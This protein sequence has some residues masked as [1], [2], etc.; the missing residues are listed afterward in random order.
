[1]TA[2]TTPRSAST[3]ELPAPQSLHEVPGWFYRADILLF[4]WFLRRQQTTGL[5]GDLL[6]LGS[7]MGKSAVLMRAYL[8]EGENFTVCDLF[9]A[10]APD[11]HN[12]QETS[13]SYRTLTRQA[14]EAN[15][16]SFHDEL[17][18]VLHAPTSV[19]AEEVPAGSCRFVHVDAS[20]LY[21]HVRSDIANAR[22][23]LG[24][25]G[26]L[27]MDDYRSSHTPGVACATWQAVLEDGLR[28]VCLTNNKFYGTW[29][30]PGPL[31]QELHDALEA[32]GDCGLQWQYV[33]GQRLLLVSGKH[34]ELP[35]LPVSRHA[36]TAEEIAREEAAKQAE[37]ERKEAEKAAEKAARERA[38]AEKR[39]A[40]ERRARTPRARVV[41]AA[42]D[43]LPPVLTRAVVRAR[44]RRRAR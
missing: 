7:Y 5:R 9:G 28:P 3:D 29:E 33:S 41:R 36:R 44:K 43:L 22:K 14:F 20:H 21:E 30:D 25:G 15:Y 34:A 37:K 18:R 16:L 4:D 31:Q 12:Q 32:R 11:T 1:V 23:L 40:A 26:L 27:A 17:P 10:D 6:E 13:G 35:G 19:V 38:A 39:A 24:A 2:P 42:K 8:S